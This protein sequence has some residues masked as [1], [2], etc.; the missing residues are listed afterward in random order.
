MGFLTAVAL[1]AFAAV[2]V[3]MRSRASKG[4][5]ASA[6]Q[7][8]LATLLFVAGAAGLLFTILV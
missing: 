3:A 1:L 6:R 8:A 7:R 4:E 2:L 5:P